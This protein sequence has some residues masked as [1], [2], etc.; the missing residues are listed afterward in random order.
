MR[1]KP[2][3]M[4]HL[5][6]VGVIAFVGP[7]RMGASERAGQLSDQTQPTVR[8]GNWA[9]VGT[10]SVQVALANCQTGEEIPAPRFKR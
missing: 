2:G 8:I 4:A 9:I 6:V 5:A 10:W 3:L 1:V 7:T